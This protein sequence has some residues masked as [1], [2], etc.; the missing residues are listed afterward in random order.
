[1]NDLY[2]AMWFNAVISF[3]NR[4]MDLPTGE[5]LLYLSHP[6]TYQPNSSGLKAGSIS[7]ICNSRS[8]DPR[9]GFVRVPG[10]IMKFKFRQYFSS[11]SAHLFSTLARRSS[12]LQGLRTMAP[13]TNQSQVPN[14]PFRVLIIGR[15][16][17]GKTSILQR[18]CDTTE[19]PTIYRID[20]QGQRSQVRSR[21]RWSP[22]SYR[23]VRFNLTL[24]LRFE[25]HILVCD[26]RL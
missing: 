2:R 22:Q 20:S 18:V 24:Q 3:T 12:C 15:A 9:A 7:E 23:L 8:A 17:A 5:S 16:N 26:G 21:S 14:D 11:L 13:Q 25:R 1:M 10:P 6:R 19:S 4:V